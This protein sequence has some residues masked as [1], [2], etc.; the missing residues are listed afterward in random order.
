MIGDPNMNLDFAP[1]GVSNATYVSAT[2][3]VQAKFG[4]SGGMEANHVSSQTIGG[5]GQNQGHSR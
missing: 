2:P 5:N 4:I 3:M 1:K